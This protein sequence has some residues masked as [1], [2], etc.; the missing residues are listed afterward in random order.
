ML[1]QTSR[2]ARIFEPLPIVPLLAQWQLVEAAFGALRTPPVA[3]YAPVAGGLAAFGL[4]GQIWCLAWVVSALLA[5]VLCQRAAVAFDGRTAALPPSHWARFFR[6][7]LWAQAIVLGAG[8]AGAAL[9][10]N[11]AVALIIAF[12]LSFAAARGGATAALAGPARGQALLIL[13]P[14]AIA[15]LTAG[16]PTFLALSALAALQAGMAAALAETSAGQAQAAAEAAAAL[17]HEPVNGTV[18]LPKAAAD[19]QKL[20]GRDQTTG[21]P[22]KHSFMHLLAQE[23]TRAYRAETALSLLLIAW[24]D[25][26][27]A[28]KSSN[29]EALD[30]LIAGIARRLRGTLHRQQDLLASLGGGRFAAVLPFTDA[31]GAKTVAENLQA[32]LRTPMLEGDGQDNAATAA[33]SIGA[34]TYC[35]KGLLPEAQLLQYAEEALAAARKTGGDKITRYDPMVATLRPPPYAAPAPAAEQA[36]VNLAAAVG[37]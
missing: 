18:A 29:Q 26:D 37:K 15:S 23:S 25:Y 32:A 5:T 8:G 31:F 9:S 36:A 6:G 1:R 4:F 7:C 14:L 22:N 3:I 2:L 33:I 19:F 35:G 10:G 30:Q 28:A 17:A 11:P 24:D 12:P 13:A 27:A 16:S 34:A 20:L 21:L